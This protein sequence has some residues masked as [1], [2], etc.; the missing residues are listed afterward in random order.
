[1]AAQLDQ[2]NYAAAELA[3][4]GAAAAPAAPPDP[5]RG[6]RAEQLLPFLKQLKPEDTVDGKVIPKTYGPWDKLKEPQRNKV[7]TFFEVSLDV[8][9]QD[10]VL[11]KVAA[12]ST[13]EE[14]ASATRQAMTNK[15]DEARLLHVIFSSAMRGQFDAMRRDMARTELDARKNGQ[16]YED[17]ASVIATFYNDPANKFTNN[18]VH[19][20]Q[21]T[22]A[23]TYVPVAGFENIAKNCHD[24]D[25]SAPNRPLRD[26]AWVRKEWK[27]LKTQITLAYMKW[28]VSG[29]QDAEGGLLIALAD[30]FD[31]FNSG[32]D[33]VLYS[34]TLCQYHDWQQLGKLVPNGIGRDTG[35]IDPDNSSN[36][37]EAAGALRETEAQARKRRRAAARQKIS[38]TPSPPGD[39]VPAQAAQ[40]AQAAAPTTGA[41]VASVLKE[42]M[43]VDSR[44][45]ALQVL[46]QY[47]S[48]EDKASYIAELRAIAASSAPPVPPAS[49]VSSPV[50]TLSS[51]SSDTS[52]S[53]SGSVA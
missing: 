34:V 18:S 47:S 38:G 33:I 43:A 32:H 13:V 19:A 41:A 49:K 17:P 24:I 23:G 16:Y 36:V 4:T 31:S 11:A 9:K 25:P 48:E 8:A 3:V 29:Q 37:A 30:N 39:S 53:G 45:K 20:G 35:L 28:N 27:K 6:A 22:A 10:E 40:A 14:S 26:G 42:Q 1:M 5:F 46:L 21:L 15:N 51:S 12:A 7:V 2:E 52:S 44:I 50:S